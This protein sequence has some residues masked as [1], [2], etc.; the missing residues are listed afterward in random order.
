MRKIKKMGEDWIDCCNDCKHLSRSNTV[1]NTE[2]NNPELYGYLLFCPK[3]GVIPQED[4]ADDGTKYID[5]KYCDKYEAKD[6]VD[7]SE[8]LK[9]GTGNE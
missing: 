5:M 6:G 8:I 2:V 9:L 3:T 1:R 4:W 7:D